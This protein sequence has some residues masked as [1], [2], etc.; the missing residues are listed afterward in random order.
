MLGAVSMSIGFYY[1]RAGRTNNVG[2]IRW[3]VLGR[4]WVVLCIVAL[5]LVRQARP[6]LLLFTLKDT[7]GLVWSWLALRGSR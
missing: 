2:F 1:L 3:S 5:V 7:A 6:V 4:A